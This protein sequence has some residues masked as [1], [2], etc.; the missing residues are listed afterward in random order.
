MNN[1]YELP[2]IIA[3]G[4]VAFIALAILTFYLLR[5]R[6][7]RRRLLEHSLPW[8]FSVADFG[9]HQAPTP[10]V[11]PLVLCHDSSRSPSKNFPFSRFSWFVSEDKLLSMRD[12]KDPADMLE[13]DSDRGIEYPEPAVVTSSPPPDPFVAI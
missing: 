11:I 2:I 12:Y 7:R 10:P 5:L 6:A 4:V 3:L 13:P 8:H 1:N 9:A